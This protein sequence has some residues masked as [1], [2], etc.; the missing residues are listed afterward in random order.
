MT[1]QSAPSL[2]LALIETGEI[3]QSVRQAAI[4]AIIDGRSDAPMEWT[5][6]EPRPSMSA[7]MA[8]EEVGT[9]SDEELFNLAQ[10][11]AEADDGTNDFDGSHRRALARMTELQT[12]LDAA[13]F[14]PQTGQKIYEVTGDKRRA[15][16]VAARAAWQ[17]VALSSF[18]AQAVA[19]KRAERAAR[20]E[21]R[22]AE[23][24]ALFAIAGTDVVRQKALQEALLRAEMDEVARQ[25]HELRKRR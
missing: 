14:D 18:T 10:Q 15:M 5:R 16:E 19:N 20:K 17:E 7:T 11:T 23:E 22:D 2:A 8:V 3:S 12:M 6:P 13:T 9:L 25:I 24:A 4:D 21:A 1:D